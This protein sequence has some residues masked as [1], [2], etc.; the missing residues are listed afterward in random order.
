[1]FVYMRIVGS[2]AKMLPKWPAVIEITAAL[3]LGALHFIMID[4]LCFSSLI[5]ALALSVEPTTTCRAGGGGTASN[6]TVSN[7]VSFMRSILVYADDTP[8]WV[9]GTLTVGVCL[10]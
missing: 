8:S 4:S 7:D 6:P 10:C 1:M 5:Y 3:P 2:C 9:G